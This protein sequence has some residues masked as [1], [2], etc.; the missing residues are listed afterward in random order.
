MP[1]N[2]W[3]TADLHIGHKNILKHQPNRIT[4]MNLS[5]EN[6]VENHDKW[7]INYWNRTVKRNDIVYIC[8][9]FIMGNK[10][11]TEKVLKKLVGQKHLILGNHDRNWLDL[12]KYFQS[13]SFIKEL[14]FKP[15]SHPF[16]KETFEVTLQHYAMLIWNKKHYGSCQVMG[17]SHGSLDAYNE[18]QNDLRVDVGFDSKLANFEFVSLEKLYNYFKEKTNGQPFLDYAIEKRK[19]LDN[20]FL[21]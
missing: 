14:K 3:F 9:D 5:S 16:L 18:S 12:N 19:E 15:E 17:H 7:L 13:V 6:D 11:F 21:V 1:Q 4:H 2:I 20:S 10:Q 8:G